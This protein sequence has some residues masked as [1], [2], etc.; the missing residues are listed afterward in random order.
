MA[1]ALLL[2]MLPNF[3]NLFDWSNLVL[4]IALLCLSC[5]KFAMDNLSCMPYKCPATNIHHDL[6]I[7]Y[8]G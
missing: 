1:G 4:I 2:D 8:F 3:F 5:L 7:N 6:K